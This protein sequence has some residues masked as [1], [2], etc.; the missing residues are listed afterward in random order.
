M[1][2][3]WITGPLIGAGIGYC[4]N[5][6]AVKMLFRPRHEL[7]LFGHRVPLTPGVIP[8]GKPRLAKAVGNA[9]SSSLLTEEDLVSRLSAPALEDAVTAGVLELLRKDT[10]GL[11][12][13]VLRTEEK[14]E[15]L[16]A[17]IADLISRE[18]MQAVGEMQI[19]DLVTREGARII[20]EKTA[21]TMLSMFISDS[22]LESVLPPVGNEVE[23]YIAENGPQMVNNAAARKLDELG[24]QSPAELLE[25]AGV[26][27]SELEQFI[28]QGYRRLIRA[29]A[30]RAISR[31]DLAG[32][33]EQKINAM[34]PAELEALVFSVMKKELGAIVNLGALIGLV[35]G[36][37]NIFL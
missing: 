27:Q 15:Q 11:E 29:G 37:L 7:R 10:K 1:M 31:L 4:T 30:A 28:R 5:Y 26:E 3:S 34:D 2:L 8:K 32:M 24:E 16:N 18:I 22:L 36:I 9:I 14:A 23:R 35:L 13:Q 21:G 20:Q 19:S 6:I 12:L 33:I 25:R 17:Q